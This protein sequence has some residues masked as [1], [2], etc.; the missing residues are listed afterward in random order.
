ME[1][2]VGSVGWLLQDT[3]D[4]ALVSLHSLTKANVCHCSVRRN[5]W[6]QWNEFMD[7]APINLHFLVL[8]V[9]Q[10]FKVI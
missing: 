7:C 3:C 2:M 6:A 5:T 1:K 9:C 8:W 10:A 4:N